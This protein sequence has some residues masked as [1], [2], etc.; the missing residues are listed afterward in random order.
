MCRRTILHE[1]EE[2]AEQEFKWWL[3]LFGEDYFVELQRH[4]IKEQEKINLL[5]QKF[6][7]KFNVPMIATN[8]S[9]YTDRD[10]Y[11]AH[12]ILLCINTGEKTGYAG[13]TTT[14]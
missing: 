12:D 10:D 9:H 11:N 7:K 6:A 14:S 5:L 2:K 13:V 8:D 3:D 1:S 4:N